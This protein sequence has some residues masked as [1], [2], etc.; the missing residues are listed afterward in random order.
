MSLFEWMEFLSYLVTVIGLP[1]AIG[2]FV[3]EQQG[4]PDNVRGFFFSLHESHTR[5]TNTPLRYCKEP[6]MLSPAFKA[7]LAGLSFQDKLEVFEAVRSSVIPLS[8]G[9]FSEL[10]SAQEQELL[11]RAKQAA[12][13]PGTGRSWAEVK[14]RIMGT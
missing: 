13:N 9:A 7:E 12:A 5:L 2:V 6:P 10:S 3:H 14:Q 8:D 4:S 1:L 11:R